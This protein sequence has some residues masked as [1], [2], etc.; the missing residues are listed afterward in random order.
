MGTGSWLG[1]FATL[2]NLIL[3]QPSR[4]D[5]WC[6][7]GLWHH[8]PHGWSLLHFKQFPSKGNLVLHLPLL[9]GR[10]ISARPSSRAF[11]HWE[12]VSGDRGSDW[13]F[14]CASQV[15]SMCATCLRLLFPCSTSETR[16][17]KGLNQSNGTSSHYDCL[18]FYVLLIQ[19]LFHGAESLSHVLMLRTF[20]IFSSQVDSATE[21]L[22]GPHCLTQHL[23][24]SNQPV[25]LISQGSPFIAA[26]IQ[27][28]GLAPGDRE[29]LRLRLQHSTDVRRDAIS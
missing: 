3:P 22:T 7:L 14:C 12:C 28:P 8:F 17:G 13:T 24:N 11:R 15:S 6:V 9:K 23:S 5:V 29:G 2:N 4:Y 20:R 10:F 16:G 25:I 18:F 19:G 27:C 1:I 21:K 26:L